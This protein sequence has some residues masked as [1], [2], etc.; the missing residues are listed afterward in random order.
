ML[1]ACRGWDCTASTALQQCWFVF[2]GLEQQEMVMCL[3]QIA[4]LSVAV[5]LR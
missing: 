4:V 5:V 2:R 1:A 3:Q